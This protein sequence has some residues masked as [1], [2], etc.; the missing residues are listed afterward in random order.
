LR[1]LIMCPVSMPVTSVADGDL[2][3][4][5]VKNSPDGAQGRRGSCSGDSKDALL[6]LIVRV[7]GGSERS[8]GSGTKRLQADLI[9][10]H[11]PA[12]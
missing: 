5:G 12:K 8:D 3:T 2:L 4:R 9:R 11:R 6:W 7:T 1:L 10:S